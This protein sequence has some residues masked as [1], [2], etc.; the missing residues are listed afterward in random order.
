MTVQPDTTP[1]IPDGPVAAEP[2]GFYMST[3]QYGAL[4]DT[5]TGAGV[6]L[7]EYDVRIATWLAGWE[8]GTVAVIASWV[9]RAAVGR[10]PAPAVPLPSR[11][12]ATPAEVDQHLRRILAE[13]TYLR[14]QQ[15]IGGLAVTEAAKDARDRVDGADIPGSP[16]ST[17]YV[18]GHTDGA[19]YVDPA[20]G[21]GPYPSQLQCS[22]HDG[23]GPCPG[24]PACTPRDT[25][26]ASR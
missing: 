24:A 6:E 8:W 2:A 16:V 25:A 12:D 17:D 3:A 9:A 21:G 15:T 4:T 7:G 22:Q 10:P 20:K 18:K 26:E 19:D 23:F 11:F 5:L 14:Y 13:D 1:P